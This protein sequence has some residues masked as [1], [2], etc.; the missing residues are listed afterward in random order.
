MFRENSMPV[1]NMNYENS[2]VQIKKKHR[3]LEGKIP[4]IIFF[5]CEIDKF[6]RSCVNKR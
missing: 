1:N 2:I 5:Q 4:L 6:S 3:L